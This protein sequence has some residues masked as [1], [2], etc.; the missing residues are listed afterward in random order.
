VIN[1]SIPEDG[2]V[3]LNIYNMVGQEVE[4]LVEEKQTRGYHKVKWN[5]NHLSTGIYFYRLTFQ[6]KSYVKRL[7]LIK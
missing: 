1:Y 4:T 7:L 5:A 2:K 6:G 3:R